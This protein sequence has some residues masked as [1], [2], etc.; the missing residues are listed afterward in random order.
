M[1]QPNQPPRD[2]D[3]VLLAL[4]YQNE[5]CHIDGKIKV[6]I[7]QDA[8]W[9]YETLDTAKRL[10]AGARAANIDIVHV[11]L[12]VRP[13]HRDVIQNNFI[14]RQWVEVGAWAEG[15][16]GVE[17]YEGLE[18]L[19]HEYV[20]THTRNNA[21]YNSQLDDIMALLRPRRLAIAGV[22]TAYVVECTARH[23]SDVGYETIV[24]S[25][26]CSTAT[27]EMHNN[28]LSAMELIAT[29]CTTDELISQL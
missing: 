22:S 3:L 2:A 14:F 10:F 4:H 23:A 17:F 16:W 11:R 12:A 29:V 21:F 15:S 8:D 28:A 24:V 5:N 20:V 19:E 26:A 18:P 13:D 25:D 27:K 9:R 6:G 7:K 1:S